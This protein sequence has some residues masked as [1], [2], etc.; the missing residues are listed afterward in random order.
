MTSGLAPGRNP[1]AGGGGRRGRMRSARRRPPRRRPRRGRRGDGGRIPAVRTPAAKRPARRS[2]AGAGPGGPR[3]PGR[4][5]RRQH[6]RNRGRRTALCRSRARG[7]RPAPRRPPGP[8]AVGERDQAESADRIQ[9]GPARTTRAGATYGHA[10]RPPPRP[11]PRR[12]CPGP[13]TRARP[14]ADRVRRPS[15]ARAGGTARRDPGRVRP[16]SG[17]P[18]PYARRRARGTGPPGRRC[19]PPAPGTGHGLAAP[20][21]AAG[22]SSP[23]R[24]VCWNIAGG[25]D[26]AS[27]PHHAQ[28]AFHSV[29][30]LANWARS[31]APGGRSRPFGRGSLAE[32]ARNRT[33]GRL[34]GCRAPAG[35]PRQPCER[36]PWER[37]EGARGEGPGR[38]GIARHGRGAGVS[39]CFRPCRLCRSCPCRRHP[40]AC[41]RRSPC[42]SGRRGTSSGPCPAPRPCR[43]APRPAIRRARSP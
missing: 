41:S 32:A 18:G 33:C 34:R 23:P 31:R 30:P 42:T 43:R 38:P 15:A 17:T 37:Q 4:S 35:Q 24:T 5:D 1:K 19:R 2:A 3:L 25:T 20:E 26:D 22:T 39:P 29:R 16:P 10:A 12:G 40:P 14:D 21:A 13:C 6:P 8:G 36:Q 11:V 7:A 9:K 27:A 28:R